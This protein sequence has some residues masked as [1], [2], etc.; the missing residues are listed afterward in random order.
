MSFFILKGQAVSCTKLSY[1][2]QNQ[3]FGAKPKFVKVLFS[4][5]EQPKTPKLVLMIMARIVPQH[6]VDV[7]CS[8]S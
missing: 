7:L 8:Q 6:N 4:N 3:H 5:H 1:C 2:S